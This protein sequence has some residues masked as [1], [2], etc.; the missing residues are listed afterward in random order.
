MIIDGTH[1]LQPIQAIYHRK[2]MVLKLFNSYSATYCPISMKLGMLVIDVISHMHTN[3][4]E[5]LSFFVGFI[6]FSVYFATPIF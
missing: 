3:F 6:G 2:C 1:H 5:V 4:C